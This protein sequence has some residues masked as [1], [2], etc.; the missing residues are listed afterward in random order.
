MYDEPYLIALLKDVLEVRTMQP[1]LLVQTIKLEK[2]QS[3]FRLCSGVLYV[4]TEVDFFQLQ[5]K[6]VDLQIEALIKQKQ[7]QLALKLCVRSWCVK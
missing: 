6:P 5:A 7:F 2:L 1:A 3:V 4:A